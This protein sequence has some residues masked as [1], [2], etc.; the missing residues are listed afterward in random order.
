MEKIVQDSSLKCENAEKPAHELEHNDYIRLLTL[1]WIP[2][3]Y[4]VRLIIYRVHG[5]FNQRNTESQQ[6]GKELESRKDD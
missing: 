4:T 3:L 5:I 2:R 1:Y 6:R